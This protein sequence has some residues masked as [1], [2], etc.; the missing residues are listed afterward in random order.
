MNYFKISLG[1]LALL[2]ASRFVP[3]PPNFTSL[4]AL[5]F[6]IPHLFGVRFIP[7]VVLSLVFTDILIGFHSTILFTWGSVIL[8]G[9]ISTIFAT[10]PLLRIFGVLTGATIFYIVSNFGVW[11]GG[12]YGYNLIG[13]IECYVLAIPFFGNTLISTLIFSLIIE[14][15]YS[16]YNYKLKSEK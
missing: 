12:S 14:C 6:Y 3:H 5:S 2:C 4:I 7:I 16:L 8:V 10:S 13:L 1:V 15:L 11:L 9:F